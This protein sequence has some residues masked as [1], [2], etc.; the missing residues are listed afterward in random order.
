MRYCYVILSLSSY[1]D[2]DCVCFSFTFYFIF[3]G[4]DYL[5]YCC[6]ILLQAFLNVHRA[7]L[8]SPY[9][10]S[11]IPAWVDL[12]FGYRQRGTVHVEY[13]FDCTAALHA[14]DVAMNEH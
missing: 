12:V 11:L 13:P 2:D 7:A 9:T 14:A 4:V 10:S 5:H 6:G 8:E 3:N 1:N